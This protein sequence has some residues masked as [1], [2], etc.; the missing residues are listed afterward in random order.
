MNKKVFYCFF[1]F[2]FFVHLAFA[3][4]YPLTV[5]ELNIWNTFHE[6][7]NFKEFWQ[8]F[9]KYDTHQPL[10]YLF[11]YPLFQ[12][13][14]GQFFLRLPSLLFFVGGGYFWNKLFSYAEKENQIPW[15]LYLFS[16]FLLMYSSFFLP[17][18]LLILASIFNYYSLSMLEKEESK[19]TFFQFLLSCLILIFTHYYGALQAILVTAYYIYR[20]PNKKLKAGFFFLTLIL[21]GTLIAFSD[22]RNDFAVVHNYR[23]MPTL[24][25][26]LGSINLL[27][28]GRY[29]SILLI[30]LL[31]WKR[32]WKIILTREFLFIVT[33]VAIAYLKSRLISPSFEARYL[34][35]LIYP[36]YALFKG[37]EIKFIVPVFVVVSLFSLYQL[38]GT[39]G[40]SFVTK[41]EKV[42]RTNEGVGLFITPCPK[43]YF[44][45]SNYLCKDYYQN[46]EQMTA[47]ANQFIVHKDHYF[48]FKRLV[49]NSE[50][51]RMQEPGLYSCRLQVK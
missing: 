23:K 3:C 24:Y 22:F 46:Y 50:C 45:S 7:Q 35:I 44:P 42:P 40:A 39:F 37:I 11:W 1:A 34:L 2:A 47:G 27:N 10:F 13:F 17:Y 29:L 36:L 21:F 19:K 30:L 4:T 33:V 48:F 14:W 26:V 32:K 43:F 12:N 16:P 41:Y 8:H 15:C 9:V 5:D 20:S 49:R 6:G 25:T 28:G 51:E 31:L 18:A 38:Q